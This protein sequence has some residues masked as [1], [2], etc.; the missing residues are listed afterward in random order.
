ME[1]V[2]GS[3]VDAFYQIAMDFLMARE[4]ENI[5]PIGIVQ[6]LRSK[7]ASHFGYGHIHFGAVNNGGEIVMV[8]LQTA[9]FSL[10]IPAGKAE[11]VGHL[12]AGFADRGISLPGVRG[13]LP[14][15]HAFAQQWVVRHN[16]VPNGV[17]PR[18]RFRI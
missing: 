2:Y 9:P 16:L 10:I 5:L 4:E 11:A 15:S 6:D 3:D 1:F 8:A 14:G 13:V 18:H 12:V 7:G 17:N